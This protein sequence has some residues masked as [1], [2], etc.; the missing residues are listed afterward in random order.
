MQ[1]E[2]VFFPKNGCEDLIN[3]LL[4]F[5]IESNHDDLVDAFS[6]GVIS[7]N[8]IKDYKIITI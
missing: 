6:M 3:Q 8:N 1:N 2:Q 5:G 4:G 7:I